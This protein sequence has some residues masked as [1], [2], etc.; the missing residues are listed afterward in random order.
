MKYYFYRQVN[1]LL[2]SN[3]AALAIYTTICSVEETILST[4]SIPKRKKLS[5]RTSKWIALIL[6]T[7]G[8]SH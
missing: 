1:Y 5:A 3:F 4:N 6:N 8:E 2:S 7:I